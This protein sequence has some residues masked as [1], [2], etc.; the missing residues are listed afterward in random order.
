[1]GAVLMQDGYPIAYMSK[2]YF[3]AEKNY[4]VSEK[5]LLAVKRALEKWR[6][7]LEGCNGLTV[8]TDHKPN[9]FMNT[10]LTRSPRLVRWYEFFQRFNIEWVYKPGRTNM[11]DPLSRLN[12]S[13]G[14]KDKERTKD[15]IASDASKAICSPICSW[16]EERS[17]EFS[18][19]TIRLSTSQ[20]LFP[21]ASRNQDT[22]VELEQLIKGGY[23]TDP[24]FQGVE[25]ENT[26]L[27]YR[28]GF[29]YLKSHPHILVVPD[30][31][32]AKEL[33]LREAHSTPYSGHFGV[34]RT[35]EAVTPYFWWP[36]IRKDVEKYVKG[37]LKCQTNKS[38]TGPL[39]WSLMPLQKPVVPWSVI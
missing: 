14:D 39:Q 22:L 26:G 6:C 28:N 35:I 2:K 24:V 10:Q 5:E 38:Q 9:T 15:E 25:V 16:S 8:V 21:S 17:K 32:E 37:C 1:M 33:I 19:P 30:R 3:G 20:A 11:A 7:Y 12:L 29:Y 4:T 36:D 18:T 27:L 13:Q 31:K 23:E 34:M